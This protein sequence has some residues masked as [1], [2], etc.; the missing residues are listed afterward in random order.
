MIKPNKEELMSNPRTE[1][2][3]ILFPLMDEETAVKCADRIMSNLVVVAPSSDT[4]ELDIT[5]R[6]VLYILETRKTI[7]SDWTST[8]VNE[9]YAKMIAHH[10][11][12][13][14]ELKGDI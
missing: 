1:I 5:A 6:K 14:F 11:H 10:I 3:R 12:K 7:P 4:N 8:Q 9:M 13:Y 2:I